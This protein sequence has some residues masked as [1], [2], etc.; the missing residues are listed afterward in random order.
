MN[1]YVCVCVWIRSQVADF[2]ARCIMRVVPKSYDQAMGEVLVTR[3]FL[4]NFAGDNVRFLARGF[5][6]PGDHYGQQST[7]YRWPYGPAGLITP[8]NFPVSRRQRGWGKKKKGEMH[9]SSFDTLVLL[10]ENENKKSSSKYPSFSSW[11]PCSWGT[12]SSSRT[13]SSHPW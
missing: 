8:F 10:G 4:E 5:T 9:K 6:V 13:P 3:K 1:L 2:F 12:R 7:G 11:E